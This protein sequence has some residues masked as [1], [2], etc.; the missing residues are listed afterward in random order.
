MLKYKNPFVKSDGSKK[1]K[2]IPFEYVRKTLEVNGKRLI[3]MIKQIPSDNYSSFRVRDFQLQEII[4]SGATDLL[5][6][7]G[8]IASDRLDALDAANYA[9]SQLENLQVDLDNST[10]TDSNE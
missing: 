3:K 10:V 2:Q 9:S 7:T 6:Q 1:S 5:T 4:E 8:T